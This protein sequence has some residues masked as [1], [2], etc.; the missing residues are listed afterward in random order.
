MI[1]L[2]LLSPIQLCHGHLSCQGF[3]SRLCW[4]KGCWVAS[5]MLGN[6]KSCLGC[7]TAGSPWV[8]TAHPGHYYLF[9]PR[10]HLLLWQKPNSWS[11]LCLDALSY[12]CMAYE[13]LT[14]FH[15]RFQILKF[16]I[17]DYSLFLKSLYVFSNTDCMWSLRL[18]LREVGKQRSLLELKGDWK[19]ISKLP[20]L[21]RRKILS[22]KRSSQ[23][24]S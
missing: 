5:Q 14:F 17:G 4:C 11:G 9:S 12:N 8:P 19:H 24:I 3:G 15:A 7:D 6:L 23:E 22:G 18:E 21:K 10:S 1:K 2:C 20:I 13:S 16:S